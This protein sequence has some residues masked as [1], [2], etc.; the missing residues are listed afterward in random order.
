M[1]CEPWSWRT[2]Q[3]ARDIRGKAAEVTPHPLTDRLE[4]LE[5]GG[6]PVGVDADTFGAAVVDGDEH[7]GLAFAGDRRRQV[8]A[9]HRVD[10]IGDDGAVMIAR[11]ARRADARGS[12]QVVLAHEP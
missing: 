9:P 1:Y 5:A 12:Q 4:R 3:S 11:P 10:R 6:L 8:G 7:G 2:A